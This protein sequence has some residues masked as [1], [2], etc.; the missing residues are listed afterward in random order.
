M[1]NKKTEIKH[2]LCQCFLPSTKDSKKIE[3]SFFFIVTREKNR[4]FLVMQKGNYYKKLSVK[5][6]KTKTF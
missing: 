5:N 2:K 1:R 4:L 3:K 6:K